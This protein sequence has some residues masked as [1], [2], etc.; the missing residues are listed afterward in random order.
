MTKKKEQN[1][2]P[3]SAYPACRQL[4]D[5][6]R[7]FVSLEMIEKYCPSDPGY[8]SY[9]LE[10]KGLLE[11]GDFS[12]ST[13]F[14][15]SETV[16]LTWLVNAAKV[17]L[18]EQ[19]IRFRLFTNSIGIAISMGEHGPSD[20][21]PVNYF[22]ASL[23][24][25]ALLLGDTELLRLL[26]PVFDELHTRVKETE[27]VVKEGMF[28]LLGQMILSFMGYRNA[29]DISLLAEQIIKE[30]DYFRP[31]YPAEYFWECTCFNQLHPVWKA[32]IMRSFPVNST[33]ESVILLREA[34]LDKGE[35]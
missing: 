22:A 10:F 18:P 17:P 13:I 35:G 30:A 9:V 12:R 19:F 11:T 6:A 16:V 27:W 33:D 21:M 34:L 14:D 31:E 15:V 4:C 26:G 23:L 8:H 5:Y 1:K 32:L 3:E 28:L 2:E 24:D 25:D 20:S 7:Q 29:E